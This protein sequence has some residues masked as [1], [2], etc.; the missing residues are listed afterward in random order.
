MSETDPYEAAARAYDLFYRDKDYEGEVEQIIG[1]IEARCPSARSVLDVGCGTGAHLESLARH[2][3]RAEGIEPSVRMLEQAAMTRPGLLV[4]PGDMRTFR[5][6]Q[7]YDAVTCLFSAIGYMTTLDDLHLAVANMAH[8][9]VDGGVLVVEGWV[10]PGEWVVG[11]ASAN[12][13]VGDDLAAARVI[14]SDREGDVSIIEM[15]YV[16]A[17][18]DAVEYID[19]VHRMGLFT[20]EQYRGALEAAGLRYERAGGLTGRGLHIGVR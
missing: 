6:A 11:R 17:T 19:E 14:L 4:Y 5:L 12:A 13:V 20:R 1:I 7:R 2:Y 10:D 9:L 16:L 18:L 15:H 3:E 8:H